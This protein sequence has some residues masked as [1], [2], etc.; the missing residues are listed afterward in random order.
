MFVGLPAD[1][2]MRLPIFETVLKGITVTGSIVGTRVDLAETF[3]LHADG[4]T[5]VVREQRGLEDVNEAMRRRRARRRRRPHRLRPDVA[6]T[7][8][9]SHVRLRDGSLLE[10]RPI[11]EAD[12]NGLVRFHG[13]L[14]DQTT[15]L[16]FFA[17]H[18]VLH[19]DEVE[20]FTHVDHRR[21]EAVVALLETRSSPSPASTDSA[22]VNGD[23]AE[24]AFVVADEFQGRGIG[25]GLLHELVR[26]ARAL[27]IRR[28]V[29]ETLPHNRRM[30]TV[31]RHAGLPVRTRF[32]D[33]T[34]HV[35]LD[36][37]D[38]ASVPPSR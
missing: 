9:T 33:G 27:G 36:L 37:E 12:A 10:V 35:V 21:R 32:E 31:F 18:P 14:S 4:R 5:T 30:L 2:V 29:A 34:V 1:N 38:V 26:R 25:T 13:R 24:V 11:E 8:L 19:A 23:E 15:Y 28:F 22:K 17:V 3:E 20:R 7:T 6:M 16:R